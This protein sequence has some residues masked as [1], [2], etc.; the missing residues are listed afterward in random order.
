MRPGWGCQLVFIKNKT[1]PYRGHNNANLVMIPTILHPLLV[2]AIH[3][4]M[5]ELSRQTVPIPQGLRHVL[6]HLT[7]VAVH[8]SGFACVIFPDDRGKL[9][10]GAFGFPH[11]VIKVDAV[12]RDLERRTV[13]HTQ[14]G[15]DVLHG[16][17]RSRCG[18]SRN[19]NVVIHLPKLAKL[20]ILS[21]GHTSV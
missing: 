1:K 13:H 10:R 8:D 6:A 5:I 18:E 3:L 20:R 17:G 16:L 9:L 11:L 2:Q 4:S 21:G 7:R 14:A 15:L 12:G 19:W